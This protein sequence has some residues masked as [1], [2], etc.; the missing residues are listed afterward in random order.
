MGI[1]KS[2]LLPYRGPLIK[3]TGHSLLLEGMITLPLTIG[4]YPRQTTVKMQFL[5]MNL[6]SA[7]NVI[8]GRT[9]LHL[10]WAIPSTY[11]Q[12][13]KFL[14]PNG[15]GVP[16]SNQREARSYYLLSTKGKGVQD[17]LP[18]EKAYLQM[19]KATER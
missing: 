11:H 7:H 9:A 1:D 15:V 3:F 13:V 8:L 17:A 2:C 19:E 4:E 10:L 18:I 16:R 5:I 14:T 6:K 12:M